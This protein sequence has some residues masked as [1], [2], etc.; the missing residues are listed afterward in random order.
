MEESKAEA[1]EEKF[2][3]EQMKAQKKQHQLEGSDYEQ[4]ESQGGNTD[5]EAYGEE[6]DSPYLKKKKKPSPSAPPPKNHGDDVEMADHN[7]MAGDENQ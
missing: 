3:K 5:R 2:A 4:E 7:E 1:K 6:D